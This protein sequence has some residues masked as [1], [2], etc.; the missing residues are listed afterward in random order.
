MTE[1]PPSDPPETPPVRVVGLCGGIAAGKSFVAARF[2]EHGFLVLDA[3]R[4][5]R[6]VTAEPETLDAIRARFGE[7]VFQGPALDRAALGAIVFG[8]PEAKQDLEAM[9]HPR[10]RERLGQ[11]LR[12]ALDAGDR[13][14][15]DVPL[16]FESGWDDECDRIVFVDT[17]RATRLQR[18]AGR[19]WDDEELARREATQL[20]IDEKRSRSDAAVPN[21]GDEEETRSAVTKLLQSWKN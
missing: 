5:A 18:A 12:A 11:A 1:T 9:L 13:V 10:I 21:D 6:E 15:L 8:D 3:D 20:P 14:V 4:V 17:T 2:R 19:G 7:R 16:L